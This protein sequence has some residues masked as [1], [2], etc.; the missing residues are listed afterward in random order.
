MA[1]RGQ[2]ANAKEVQKREPQVAKGNGEAAF[3]GVL[4]QPHGHQGHQGHHHS[5]ERQRLQVDAPL[6]LVKV[7]QPARDFSHKPEEHVQRH[8][9]HHDVQMPY[10]APRMHAVPCKE[11][12]NQKSSAGLSG[13]Y[14]PGRAKAD[15][16]LAAVNQSSKATRWGK[17]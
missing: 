6:Q 4:R 9:P 10:N 2:V 7:A 11:I 12:R 14:W 13:R 15:F 3:W 5:V 17:F 16:K 8:R 1:A